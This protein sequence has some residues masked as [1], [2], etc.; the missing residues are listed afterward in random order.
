MSTKYKGTDIDNAYFITITTVG[1][2]AVVTD[3][4]SAPSDRADFQN[5]DRAEKHLFLRGNGTT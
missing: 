2:A 5:P 3:C 4:K 1:L